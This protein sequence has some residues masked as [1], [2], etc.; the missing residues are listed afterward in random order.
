[1]T[2]LPTGTSQVIGDDPL[3]DKYNY[4]YFHLPERAFGVL[5]QMANIGFTCP[6]TNLDYA[7]AK[8]W[9]HAHKA[10]RFG[11]AEAWEAIMETDSSTTAKAR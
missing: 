1:M 6:E 7:S 9:M 4:I 10:M 5:S 8:Q 11:D 2:V 3:N